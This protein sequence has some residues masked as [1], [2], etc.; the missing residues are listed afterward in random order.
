MISHAA[1]RHVHARPLQA[2][3][4]ALY[5]LAMDSFVDQEKLF[6]ILRET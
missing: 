2:T 3:H 4:V 6:K 5:Y 1:V